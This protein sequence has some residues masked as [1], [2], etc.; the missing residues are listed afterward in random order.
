VSVGCKILSPFPFHLSPSC[1]GGP[2]QAAPAR[3]T[4]KKTALLPEGKQRSL[5]KAWRERR[6]E[7]SLQQPYNLRLP[8]I[9]ELER[10]LKQR[11]QEEDQLLQWRGLQGSLFP[12]PAPSALGS[13]VLERF[14]IHAKS[15]APHPLEICCNQLRNVRNPN[16]LLFSLCLHSVF[17]HGQTKRACNTYG[18]RP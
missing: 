13:Y 6:K 4:K 15:R 14:R 2:G 10:P 8:R 7:E 16:I 3:R 11:S 17:K 12:V 9:L 18:L 5:Q 1:G